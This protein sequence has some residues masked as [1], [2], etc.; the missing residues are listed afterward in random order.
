MQS[1]IDHRDHYH[2]Y[3]VSLSC[4]QRGGIWRV[5]GITIARSGTLAP[6]FPRRALPGQFLH[7]DDA[8]QRGM[9]WARAVIDNLDPE[10]LVEGV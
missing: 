4:V 2:G 10:R 5:A 3:Q 1:L 7:S 6:L 8:V 9:G